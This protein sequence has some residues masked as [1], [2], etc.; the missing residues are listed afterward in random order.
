V[1]VPEAGAPWSFP[2]HA[3]FA[4]ADRWLGRKVPVTPSPPYDL[5]RRYLAGY[6]PASAADAQA[7]SGLAGPAV[8]DAI[9]RL[10]PELRSF[11]DE[12]K[13]E[14]VDLADAPRPDAD[15]PAPVRLVP[16]YDNLITARADERFVARGH[17]PHVFLSALRI[18]ATV[19]VDGF[20]AATWKLSATRKA[21]TVTVE[22]FATLAARVRKEV[23]AEAEALARFAEPEARAVDVRFTTP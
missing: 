12:H 11:R 10:R 21:A 23:S 6:G 19:L 7:W 5:I 4:Q 2:A 18:A 9:E 15:V 17:R 3:R 16:E 20:V 22:P 1:Q 8:R 13:R 14:I